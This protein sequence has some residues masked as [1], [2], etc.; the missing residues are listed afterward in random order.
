MRREAHFIKSRR[1]REGIDDE[2][3]DELIYGILD[4]E[5]YNS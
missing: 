2:W 3:L 5:W 4:S 1:G